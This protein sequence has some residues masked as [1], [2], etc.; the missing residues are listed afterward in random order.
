MGQRLMSVL[1]KKHAWK[2]NATHH[3]RL[4]CHQGVESLVP[5]V[6]ERNVGA[7]G[8]LQDLEQGV[9]RCEGAAALS[10]LVSPIHAVLESEDVYREDVRWYCRSDGHRQRCLITDCKE[11]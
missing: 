5:G 8:H 3:H 1:P 9:E 10:C 7:D 6:T 11:Y 4:K 2:A